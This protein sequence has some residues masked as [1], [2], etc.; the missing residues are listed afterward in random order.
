MTAVFFE[1][2]DSS[3]NDKVSSNTCIDESDKIFEMVQAMSKEH[4]EIFE[5]SDQRIHKVQK[6]QAKGY[7]NRNAVGTNFEIGIKVLKLDSHQ[8]G[9]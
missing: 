2:E 7:N 3:G 5:T 4:K 8:L 1:C 9:H 6:Y